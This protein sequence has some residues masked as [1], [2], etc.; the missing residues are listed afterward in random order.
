[1]TARSL[2]VLLTLAFTSQSA[3]YR[4]EIETFRTQREAEIAGPTGWAAL[5]GL[6]WLVPGRPPGGRAAANDVV[7]TALSAPDRLGTLDV[8]AGTATLVLA[9]GIAATAAGRAVRTVEL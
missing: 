2:A 4:A 1:M 7:L 8:H 9:D 5:A 6:H 3:S